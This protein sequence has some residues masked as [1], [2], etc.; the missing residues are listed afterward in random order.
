MI[1]KAVEV[2]Q[3]AKRQGINISLDKG[4][5]QLKFSKGTKINA[6]LLQQIKDN[7]IIITDFLNNNNWKSKK[8]EDFENELRPFDRAEITDIP[9]SFSQERLWFIH[10]L[11]GTVK[12]HLPSVLRLNGDLNIDA[13]HFAF[14]TIVNRHEVLRS[15]FYEREGHG[16]QRVLAK[17]TW[18]LELVDRSAYVE[19]DGAL[20]KYSKQLIDKPFDLSKDHMLR[21]H[22]IELGHQDYLLVATMHHIASDG[23]SMSVLV[24]EL[25]ELYE[26][27]VKKVPSKLSPLEIQFADYAVWQRR[28]LSG[29]NLNN[30]LRY[31]KQKLGGVT[32]LELNTDYARP[33]VMGSK[34]AVETFSIDKEL[35]QNL[36]E[37]SQKQGTTL[38]MTLLAAFKVLLYKYSGQSDIC[39]GTPIA[40]RTQQELEGLIGFFV[41]TLALRSDVRADGSFIDFLQEVKTTVLGAYEHQEV[42]FE[43]V[44]DAVVK[45]RNISRNPIFQVM[46]VLKNTPDIP[47]LRLGDITFSG[48]G[49]EHTTALFDIT[50][51]VTET[52][53]GLQC[54]LEYS[55]ELYD[56]STIK[57]IINHFRELVA[58]I[59]EWP[60]QKIGELKMLTPQEENKLLLDF[61][62]TNVDYPKDKT[63]VD[64]FEE[65]VAKTPEAI[66][67]TFEGQELTYEQLNTKANQLTRHLLAKGVKQEALI[68]ICI[69]RSLDMIVGLL[70]ILKA[71][72]AYVPIDP[73]Y[74]ED[75]IAFML[76]DI[77]ATIVLTSKESRLK[78]PAL[79]GV[80]I[81]EIDSP[82]FSKY[83]SQNLAG[84]A[85]SHSVA[86]IIYTSGS[87]GKPKGVM[88]EHLNV[89][90]LFKTERPLFDFNSKDVW[91]M[92]HSFCF[93][94]SVW[95]MYGALLFGGKLVIV[96]AEATRDI[97][98]FSELLMEEKV[99]VLNQTP[100]AFYNLQDY[101][102]ERATP[103]NVRYVIFGGEALNVAKLQPWNQYYKNCRLINM[104]GI[105]ETTVHV[106]YIEILPEHIST[107]KSFIGK[108]IP[109][110]TAYILDSSNNIVPIGVTGE[111]HI[112]GAG[113][114][115][116]YL[117]LPVLTAERFIQNPFSKE[118]GCRLYKTGDL[119]RWLPN[120]NI[121]YMGRIDDQV[122]IRGYRIELGEIE[123]V[124]L[125]SGLVRQAV[126]IARQE[127]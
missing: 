90:R 7:K 114:A 120:G 105:T 14:Q 53:N 55:T 112:G 71:G 108:P 83:P 87:T 59:V 54:A 33:T 117:N 88:V 58:S 15:V 41:N 5:L 66:A 70:G 6:D 46:F 72:A 73:E 52:T 109:T 45:E 23:W 125:Q 51:S 49:N 123:G 94:F 78:I 2:L 36:L 127:A 77:A 40:N 10:Q 89:V 85:T 24:N 79:A 65:Q 104:Y 121:E 107:G 91:T 63:L 35:S 25:V 113:L 96:P 101:V 12:Y 17:D 115:R 43:K 32:P 64:L 30:K 81:V 26:S 124:V 99:T 86:Y 16:Y 28:Y 67:I 69:E 44:V 9:L 19:E 84:L 76:K 75:R 98:L 31:W 68:P 22:L 97:S 47:A 103:L 38:F 29:K 92:F 27:A 42:P 48:R 106:T 34:G 61:N 56:S 4:E 3:N 11:E 57:G 21:A 100:T 116:G 39:I 126:V 110:L 80:E 37:F 50:F 8:V 93:D 102:V 119:G 13:L 122:K 74:P 60:N 111:L 62:D 20:F 118:T 1:S 18:K 82:E 95:E